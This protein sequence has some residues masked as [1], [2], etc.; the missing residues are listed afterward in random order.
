[1]EKLLQQFDYISDAPLKVQSL[2]DEAER[3]RSRKEKNRLWG[4]A[5]TLADAYERH[6]KEGGND[7]K[8]F[9]QILTDEQ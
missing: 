4:Q 1:M 3:T 9:N 5:Q 8:Q 7:K 6:C 2:L